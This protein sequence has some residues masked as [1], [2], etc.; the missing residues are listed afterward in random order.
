M[1]LRAVALGVLV[2]NHMCTAD[3]VNEQM[4]ASQQQ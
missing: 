4:G 3:D 1:V 2:S